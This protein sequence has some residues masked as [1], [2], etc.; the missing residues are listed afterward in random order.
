[1]KEELK[2]WKVM[3]G[4]THPSTWNEFSTCYLIK[5]TNSTDIIAEI[6]FNIKAEA[7]ARLIAAAPELLEACQ[8]IYD[9]LTYFTGEEETID[10]DDNISQL[11]QTITKIT[12]ET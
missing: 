10:W 6:R 12:K 11:K 9:K 3:P 8:N 2:T 7:N 1:M 4:Y 5:D